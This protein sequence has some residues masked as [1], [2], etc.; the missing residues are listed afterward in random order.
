MR[1]LVTGATGFVGYAVAALL[2]EH[3][4]QV[5]GLTRSNATA[6]PPGVRRIRA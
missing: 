6:L 2:V 4:H 1:V 5:D 3:G